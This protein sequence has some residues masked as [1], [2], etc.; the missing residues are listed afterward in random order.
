MKICSCYI[1]IA[2]F[3]LVTT[4]VFGQSAV[5]D[6]TTSPASLGWWPVLSNDASA[7][8]SGGILTLTASVNALVGYQAPVALWAEVAND[9]NGWEVGTDMRV[10]S[11]S[12]SDAFAATINFRTGVY[13]CFFSIFTDHIELSGSSSGVASHTMDTTDVAHQYILSGNSTHVDVRVDGALVMSIDNLASDTN[14]PDMGF[15]NGSWVNAT[16][17]EWTYLAFG[18][19]GIVEAEKTTWGDVKALF[20]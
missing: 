1:T 15:G 9:P 5:L 13:R 2:V 11:V 8:L 4:P 18:S 10:V 7:T 12:D 20:R 16:T 19:I 6:M 3:L 17:T 14:P